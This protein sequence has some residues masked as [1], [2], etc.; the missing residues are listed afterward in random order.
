MAGWTSGR[1][2]GRFL[3]IGV[4][5]GALLLHAAAVGLVV[6]AETGG[7]WSNVVGVLVILL[8]RCSSLPPPAACCGPTAAASPACC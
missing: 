6:L 4:A 2:P 1:P 8:A 3:L 7:Q 5:L